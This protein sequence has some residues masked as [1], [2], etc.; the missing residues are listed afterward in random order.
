MV[1]VWH[2]QQPAMT[3]IEDTLTYIDG[4]SQW[5]P[6]GWW[7][8]FT[9]GNVNAAGGELEWQIVEG[10]VSISLYANTGAQ[11]TRTNRKV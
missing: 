2:G 3:T 8:P 7:K 4:S 5:P 6:G 11:P 1:G 10:S 9:V